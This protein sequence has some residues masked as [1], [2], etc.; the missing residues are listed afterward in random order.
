MFLVV[1][2]F[3]D[4]FRL[5]QAV[6]MLRWGS[7]ALASCCFCSV[8]NSLDMFSSFSFFWEGVKRFVS[9]F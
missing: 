5:F 4:C 9:F 1:V 6:E 8:W 3:L 7:V 2:H